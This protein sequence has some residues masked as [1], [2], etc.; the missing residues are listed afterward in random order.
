MYL[1]YVHVLVRDSI[2]T[3]ILVE[4]GFL[5]EKHFRHPPGFMTDETNDVPGDAAADVNR[6]CVK[7]RKLATANVRQP[8][9][10]VEK[11]TEDVWREFQSFAS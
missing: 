10:Q 8:Q 1:P 9:V 11:M 2:V 6:N 7:K 3:C 4:V 5:S